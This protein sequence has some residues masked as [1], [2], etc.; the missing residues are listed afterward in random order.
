MERLQSTLLVKLRLALADYTSEQ[1]T[2]LQSLAQREL[3]RGVVIAAGLAAASSLLVITVVDLLSSSQAVGTSWLQVILPSEESL[4]VM[5]W[6]LVGYGCLA[7]ALLATGLIVALSQPQRLLLPLAGAL[8]A[9]LTVAGLA[10]QTMGYHASV[11]GLV[12]GAAVLLVLSTAHALA[13]LR[14]PAYSLYAS[15]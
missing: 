2:R 5:G 9:D 12:A 8:V 11:L 3:W 7:V 4:L 6:G 14:E 13:M 10:A 1:A 15:T